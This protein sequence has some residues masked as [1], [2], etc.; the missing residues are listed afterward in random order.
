MGWE[1]WPSGLRWDYLR[2]GV[3]ALGRGLCLGAGTGRWLQLSTQPCSALLPTRSYIF[4]SHLCSWDAPSCVLQPVLGAASRDP[5]LR[6][7]TGPPSPSVTLFAV[8][9]AAE[10]SPALKPP[11][12]PPTLKR[13]KTFNQSSSLLFSVA[14]TFSFHYLLSFCLRSTAE[15]T[16]AH[17]VRLWR[18]KACP[19]PRGLGAKKNYVSR[20]QKCTHTSLPF[21][22]DKGKE[23]NTQDVTDP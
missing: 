22:W 1:G 21:V 8:A 12:A 15:L 7:S 10:G 19:K 3:C 16:M 4:S 20:V 6:R 18:R 23:E 14:F 9:G 5:Y 2:G 11:T 13:T 17:T